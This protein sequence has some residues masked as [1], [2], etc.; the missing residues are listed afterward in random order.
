MQLE[1]ALQPRLFFTKVLKRYCRWRPSPRLQMLMRNRLRKLCVNDELTVH[2]KSNFWM[3]VSPRDYATYGIYFF[4]TYDPSM[5]SVFSHLVKPGETVW[6]IGTERGWFTLHLAKL[7][8]QTGRVDSF[9]AF[10]PT[11][12]KLQANVELNKL[13]WVNTNCVGVSNKKSRM[14]FV[15]P[16]NAVTNNISFLNDCSGV[17]YLTDEFQ[18][19]AIEVN[20]ISLDDYYTLQNIQKLSL[21]KM[22]IEGAEVSALKGAQNLIVKDKPII[23]IEFNRQTAL[24]AGSSVEELN[25]LLIS[26]GYKM[27]LFEGRFIPFNLADHNGD[28]VLNVYCF[29]N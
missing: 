5:T 8:G 19:G 13:N 4:G 11:F 21:I 16:S 9:E 24:R 3:N 29:P 6:D 26:Y 17:G 18:K 10:P 25:E 15:P 2:V 1:L 7:V 23:A 12:K 28:I 22:D 27:Y 20:T 14:W